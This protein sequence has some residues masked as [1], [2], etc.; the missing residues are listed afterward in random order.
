MNMGD[1]RTRE[2]LHK[3]VY[4]LQGGRWVQGAAAGTKALV[5]CGVQAKEV[6]PLWVPSGSPQLLNKRDAQLEN[7]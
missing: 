3:L 7:F 6:S 1:L 5:A 2:D 4:T